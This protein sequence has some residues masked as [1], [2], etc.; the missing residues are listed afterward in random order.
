MRPFCQLVLLLLCSLL[1]MSGIAAA[2]Q[3]DVPLAS[4]ARAAH[5]QYAWLTAA[6]AVQLSG[7][8]IVLIIRP[9]NNLYE[10]NGRVEATAVTPQYVSGDIYISSTLAHH[11]EAMAGY[12]WNAYNNAQAAQQKATEV[13]AAQSETNQAQLHGTIV[14]NAVPLKGQEALLISGEAPPSAPVLIT[15]LAT[16]SYDLPNVLISRHTL[17]A[18]PD[19]K[20]QA[21]IPTDD[22]TRGSFLHVLATSAPGVTPAS[23]Q[24][25]VDAPNP[26]V[27]VPWEQQPG[28][29][30]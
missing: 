30:W 22:Y 5:L 4:V 17:T 7:P 28:G 26:S 20:F 14:L 16:L 29:I 3:Q 15:L 27:T 12:A 24:I 9:G 10:V 1:S 18:A 25:L 23:A 2:A 13:E 19:G 8:G 21:I 6:Q 11:I